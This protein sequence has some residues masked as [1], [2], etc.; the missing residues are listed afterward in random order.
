MLQIPDTQHTVLKWKRH[1]GS[2]WFQWVKAL[3]S[4]LYTMEILMEWR[5]LLDATLCLRWLSR[6]GK[7][8]ILTDIIAYLKRNCWNHFIRV[9]PF[10]W[11]NLTYDEAILPENYLPSFEELLHWEIFDLTQKSESITKGAVWY[12]WYR[13][14]WKTTM[15]TLLCLDSYEL[16]EWLPWVNG[17]SWALFH[18]G[19]LVH[20]QWVFVLMKIKRLELVLKD[21]IVWWI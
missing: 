17:S 12:D 21:R 16:W 8:V 9:I 13:S 4:W 14:S 18:S 3:V 11:A 5:S 19:L 15:V 2:F 20:H 10:D 7:R 1:A 6:T